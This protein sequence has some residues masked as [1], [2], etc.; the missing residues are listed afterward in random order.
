MLP[1]RGN[2]NG[3]DYWDTTYPDDG[4]RR[5]AVICQKTEDAR[6]LLWRERTCNELRRNEMVL[7]KKEELL[8][9][10]KRRKKGQIEVKV[11]P[12]SLVHRFNRI[13]RNEAK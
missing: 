7:Q 6:N 12:G 5:G 4:K 8:G 2:G 11:Q 1:I 9:H 3:S 13:I 10:G